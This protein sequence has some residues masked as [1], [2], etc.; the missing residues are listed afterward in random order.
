MSHPA[1][2]PISFGPAASPR[3]VS[4]APEVLQISRANMPGTVAFTISF[5]NL[6][7]V[8]DMADCLLRGSSAFSVQVPC[9]SIRRSVCRHLTLRVHNLMQPSETLQLSPRRVADHYGPKPVNGLVAR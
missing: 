3:L 9:K 5:Y 6:Q 1:S 4:E 2:S 7:C 8:L